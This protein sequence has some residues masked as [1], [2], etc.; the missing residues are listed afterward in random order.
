[1]KHATR[2]T[3]ARCWIACAGLICIAAA[4]SAQ[5]L[6]AQSSDPQSPRTK[7]SEWKTYSYPA[8]GF[9]AAFPS[10]PTE[11]K[12]SVQ[13]NAGTFELH[14]YLVTNE[15]VAL[16]IGVCDYGE[17]VAGADPNAILEGARN[18]AVSKVN[19]HLISSSK[20]TL[21]GYPGI[22]F[23]V[24]TGGSHFFGRIYLVTTVLYQAF[25]ALPPEQ[26]YPN[27]G[28]FFDSFQFTPHKSP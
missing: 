8:E 13:T 24:E 23:E 14:T 7:P 2:A 28:K 18:G 27:T 20:V 26:S 25:V 9:R 15:A 17:T 6:P 1:M 19:G 22:A 3:K 5:A 11:Q 16:Y 4:L 12:Q 10:E 21:G